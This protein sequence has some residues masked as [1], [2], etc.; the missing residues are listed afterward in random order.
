VVLSVAFGAAETLNEEH[1]KHLKE[2]LNWGVKKALV[3]AML[4]GGIFFVA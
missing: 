3:G 1:A 4:L 2:A